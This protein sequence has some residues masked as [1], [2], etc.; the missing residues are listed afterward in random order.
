MPV[1]FMSGP[2]HCQEWVN[3][4]SYCC[5][6]KVFKFNWVTLSG[7]GQLVIIMLYIE[8]IQNLGYTTNYLSLV[9]SQWQ[10]FLSLVLFWFP[11]ICVAFWA[12]A[13]QLILTSCFCNCHYNNMLVLFVA[14]IKLIY[15]TFFL[16]KVFLCTCAVAL[17]VFRAQIS[18]LASSTKS[19]CFVSR[20]YRGLVWSG[21]WYSCGTVQKIDREIP[22][23]AIIWILTK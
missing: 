10:W 7:T 12:L 2:L 15:L 21:Q 13:L 22:G 1:V 3:L 8:N 9:H 18:V 19:Q 4:S 20:H 16:F 5:L 14:L 17:D 6:Q 23:F 11:A